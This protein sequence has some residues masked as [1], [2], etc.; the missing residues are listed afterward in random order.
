MFDVT[1]NTNSRYGINDDQ[2]F[3]DSDNILKSLID[4]IYSNDFDIPNKDS[5]LKKYDLRNNLLKMM[6][7]IYKTFDAKYINKIFFTI[8]KDMMANNNEIDGLFKTSI[9][10][11]T[12]NISPKNYV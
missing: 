7:E 2:V 3:G 10:S 1:N 12:C 6:D 11:L 8:L 5:F 4:L 9:I